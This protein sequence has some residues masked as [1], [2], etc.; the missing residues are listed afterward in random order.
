M[1][2]RITI[3]VPMQPKFV[4]D[5]KCRVYRLRDSIG[6]SNTTGTKVTIEHELLHDDFGQR[7]H[8][9][10]SPKSFDV[11]FLVRLFTVTNLLGLTH[12]PQE[13]LD[14]PYALTCNRDGTVKF[15]SSGKPSIRIN[16]DIE[17][18]ANLVHHNLLKLDMPDEAKIQRMMRLC[19]YIYALWDD[20]GQTIEKSKI[21]Q[22]I[23]NLIELLVRPT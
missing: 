11:E 8:I 13:A 19:Q 3:K 14:K 5:S 12:I 15:S 18:N 20:E 22:T 23:K 4:F 2:K 16:K 7:R 21:S 1:R 17:D 9:I 10:K 6:R